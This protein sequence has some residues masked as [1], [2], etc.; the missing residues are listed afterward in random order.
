[1]NN[2]DVAKKLHLF[3]R[4]CKDLCTMREFSF[5][6]KA[7]FGGLEARVDELQRVLRD[8]RRLQR[9][10]QKSN[11]TSSKAKLKMKRKSLA[12]PTTDLFIAANKSNHDRKFGFTPWFSPSAQHEWNERDRVFRSSL[13]SPHPSHAPLRTPP[14]C[15]E[16][17]AVL[18]ASS[19]VKVHKCPARREMYDA[20]A[21]PHSRDDRFVPSPKRDK[22]QRFDFS[23]PSL[24]DEGARLRINASKSSPFL[25]DTNLRGELMRS[26]SFRIPRELPR[27]KP[28]FFGY[29]DRAELARN[30]FDLIFGDEGKCSQMN[31]PPG[32]KRQRAAAKGWWPPNAP[33]PA[34][35]GTRF[36]PHAEARERAD[37]E[38]KGFRGFLP[39]SPPRHKQMVNGKPHL[40]LDRDPMFQS[41]RRPPKEGAAAR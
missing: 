23:M 11:P 17:P 38:G 9:T 24:K 29:T 5:G 33:P 22:A 10:L 21:V 3:E 8:Q 34:M 20:S 6:S 30:R 28:S 12:R 19:Q 1:M 35:A 39:F 36:G 15:I 26:Y 32:P 13:L 16:E 4:D 41:W 14:S 18:R 25:R 40:M 27:D 31:P 37:K 2:D 7:R